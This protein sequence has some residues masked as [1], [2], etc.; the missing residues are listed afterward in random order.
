MPG[1]P[2][3][4]LSMARLIAAPPD[5][6]EQAELRAALA[7]SAELRGRWALVQEA[8]ALPASDGLHALPAEEIAAYVEGTLDQGA[9]VRIES[10]AWRSLPLIAEIVSACRFHGRT[11]EL[12]E[13]SAALTRRLLDM[14]LSAEARKIDRVQAEVLPPDGVPQVALQLSPGRRPA[15]TAVARRPAALWA[16]AAAIVIAAGMLAIWV[17]QSGRPGAQVVQP[18]GQ[19][20]LTTGRP[21]PPP[22]PAPEREEPVQPLPPDGAAAEPAA[23]ESAMEDI[24]DEGEGPAASDGDESAPPLEPEAP[25]VPAPTPEAPSTALATALAQRVEIDWRRIEGLL[26]APE[27]TGGY[28]TPMAGRLE[29]ETNVL[30]ATLPDSWAEGV[31][32]SGGTLVLGPDTRID[33]GWSDDGAAPRIVLAHGSVAVR[34]LRQGARVAFEVAGVPWTAE[35]EN[36]QTTIAAVWDAARPTAVVGAG[37]AGIDGTTIGAGRQAAWNGRSWGPPQAVRGGLGWIARPPKAARVPPT[38]L[39]SL[40]AT[41]NVDRELAALYQHARPEV[42]Q[43]AVRWR[44]AL[45]DGA[46]WGALGDDDRAVRLAALQA[47]SQRADDDPRQQAAWL[48]IAAGLN[49]P[50]LARSLRNWFALARQG[51]SPTAAEAGAMFRG[52]DHPALAVRQA[53][54]WFLERFTSQTTSYD[55]QAASA[56]R[57]PG[58]RQWQAIV[59][60]TFGRSAGQRQQQNQRPGR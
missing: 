47:L 3:D 7:T 13:V 58:V 37:R 17:A 9:A 25:P 51:A 23:G 49:D 19:G 34:D 42:R 10:E 28:I 59:V 41:D 5:A 57:Q 1:G 8:A 44:A 24:G 21:L 52:L 55:P 46:L 31:L 60:R 29:A 48:A 54:A 26:V 38:V 2:W 39:A 40:R 27:G 11:S 30:L 32:G 14:A 20:D 36:D 43:V 45:D 50:P 18:G 35:V 16:A 22:R 53:A 33:L 15:A 56:D 12:P 4:L 6:P